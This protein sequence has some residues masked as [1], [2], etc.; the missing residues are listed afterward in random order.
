MFSVGQKRQDISETGCV[1][2][3]RVLL[4]AWLK[5]DC[6]SVPERAENFHTQT[7]L[8]ALENLFHFCRRESFKTI[9]SVCYYYYYN[10]HF[11]KYII[12]KS[13]SNLSTLRVSVSR[14]IKYSFRCKSSVTAG[15]K[16]W[17]R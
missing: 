1:L 3:Y 11:Y 9:I 13:T 8:S 10:H 17:A 5:Q 14:N 12:Y 4:A 6:P 7:R 15:L 2:I 16:M